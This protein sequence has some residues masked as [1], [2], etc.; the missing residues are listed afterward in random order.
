MRALIGMVACLFLLLSVGYLARRVGIIDDAL[1]KGLSRL[2]IRIG[3]PA[4]I[5]NSLLRQPYSAEGSADAFRI[6]GLGFLLHFFM[7]VYAYLA[8][9]PI[10]DL[11]ERKL[12]EFSLIFTNCGFIGFP[13]LESVLGDTGLFWGAFYIISF[14]ILIWTW[15]ILILS[16]GRADIRPKLKSIFLNFGTVPCAVGLG[17]YFSRLPIPDFL[18]DF[19]GYTASICTPISM[20][21]T[22]ALLATL[23][24]KSLFCSG[25]LYLHSLHK[26]ILIPLAVCAVM[27]LLG[28]PAP[29]IRF[30]VIMAAM[31]SG[32][33]I[34]M[35]GETYAIKPAYAALTVGL[36]SLLSVVSIPAVM[37]TVEKFLS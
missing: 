13:I 21:I 5:I 9:R 33:V 23:P 32:A 28:C 6:L 1:S 31:P 30:A 25:R 27:H 2:I 24:F 4:L 22:G 12:S 17:F 8:C 19:T 7:A 36:T 10:R 26:L 20:F 16:R 18:S 29:Y 3:Q 34:T 37:W 14:H 11:D 15:G 35:F